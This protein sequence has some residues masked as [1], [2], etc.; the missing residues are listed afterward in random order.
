MA[1]EIEE[2]PDITGCKH[3]MALSDRDHVILDLHE[4][5]RRLAAFEQLAE[6]LAPL[7]EK[8]KQTGGGAFG[9]MRPAGR[10]RP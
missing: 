10:R 4:I 3:D 6:D 9:L 2:T 1:A 7:I 8:Y 5:L